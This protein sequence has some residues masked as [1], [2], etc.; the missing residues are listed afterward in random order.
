M[1]LEKLDTCLI[2]NQNSTVNKADG[3]YLSIRR[4]VACTALGGNLLLVDIGLISLPQAEVDRGATCEVL[5]DG[6]ERK[7]LDLVVVTVLQ[8]TLTRG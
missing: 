1:N 7:A 5:Q 3:E 6:V 2:L 8:E 4:P